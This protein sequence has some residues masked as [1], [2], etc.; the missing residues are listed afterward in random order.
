MRAQKE[1]W[2]LWKLFGSNNI[3]KEKI[4][5]K[6]FCFQSIL[7]NPCFSIWLLMKTKF[8]K[9]IL[10]GDIFQISEQTLCYSYKKLN[11]GMTC[12]VHMGL[13]LITLVKDSSLKMKLLPRMNAD[14]VVL[15]KI[16]CQ[17]SEEKT[18][19]SINLF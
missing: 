14:N 15:E 12:F 1:F 17:I 10:A 16:S 3:F 4:I 13:L 6:K 8:K 7:I 9:N 5:N 11:A 2:I 18:F 19:I